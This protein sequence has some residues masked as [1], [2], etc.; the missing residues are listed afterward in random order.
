MAKGLI[1]EAREL[2][3]KKLMMVD[4]VQPVDSTQA[5]SQTD[6]Q[7]DS[8]ADSARVPP[9]NWDSMVDN[10]S[11]SQVGWSF[12]D[13]ERNKFAVDGQWWLYKRMFEEQRL[14]EQ[15]VDEGTGAAK[16]KKEAAEA[17]DR[18]IVRFQELILIIMY[19]WGGQ[20]PRTPE[21][22]GIRWKNT[23]QGGIRNI[24]I[25]DGLVAW[26]AAYHK[27]YRHSGNIKTIH[28]YLPREVGELLVYYLWLVVSFHDK[29]Q[30]QAIGQRCNSAFLWGNGEKKEHRQWTGP[31]RGRRR[32]K[33][34]KDKERDDE[35]RRNSEEVEDGEKG[36]EMAAEWTSE[37]MRKIMQK[38]SMRWMGVKIPIRGWREVSI[39][40]SR[41]F[42]RENA[43]RSGESGQDGDGWEDDV[44][45][46]P[47]DLQA[48]HGTHVA[49]MIYARELMEGRDAI[50]SRREKFRQVS[51]AWHRFLK[52]D[53]DSGIAGQKRKRSAVGDGI[54][55]AQQAR[56]KRLREV[57]IQQ[58]L[59]QMMGDKA[60]FRGL[61]EPAIKAIMKNESPILVVMS[62]GA[63][64]TL[65]FQLP[66]HS[67][68]SGTTV[69]IVPLKSLERDLHE[70]CQKAGISCI[71]W[72][73]R[74][75][76][77]MAQV[78]L[79]QP[80]SAVTMKFAQYLNRLQG[81]GRLDRV[82]FEECHTMMDSQP[83]FRP[84]MKKAGELM[85][86]RG[87]QLVYLTATLPPADE[88]EFF[89]IM[90]VQSEDV[91]I[92]RGCTS[93]PNIEYS[94]FE[95]DRDVEETEAVCQLVAEKL[96]Q[97]PAPAK[98]IVYGSSIDT[99]EELGR[100]LNCHKYYHDVGSRAQKD[101][102]QGRWESADGRVIV[103]SNAFGLGIDQPDVRVV[104]HVG[105]IH[106]LRDYVQES[107]RAGR[108]GKR[109]EAIIMR[110]EGLQEAM[111]QQQARARKAHEIP[112][113]LMTADDKKRIERGKVDKFISG[114]Q[115]RR[116]HLDQ[117][118][119]GRVDRVGCED[120]EEKCDVCQ[121][122]DNTMQEAEAL[123][124][125]YH[126]EQ[127][128]RV[129]YEQEWMLDS[130]IDIPS[131]SMM[132]KPVDVPSS[133][134]PESSIAP[135]LALSCPIAVDLMTVKFS[136]PKCQRQARQPVSPV[137]IRDLPRKSSPWPMNANSKPSKPEDNSSMHQF[138]PRIKKK[139][140]RCGNSSS[141]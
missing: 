104:I 132:A 60:E 69:V 116:I 113:V 62:T 71:R 15:F 56:W 107:G 38:S 63:G 137:P 124:Q 93:R 35:S 89:N 102:I 34:G 14:R 6:S 76:E 128:E 21:I 131:S 140:G 28:R 1:E 120:G 33:E 98:I 4:M 58:E 127:E 12:L 66:A 78:V 45:N 80:E 16:I 82:V 130:G 103:A 134:Q 9:I 84:K 126:A 77:R 32:D 53:S 112:R 55:E 59:K 48:G 73:A 8:Q 2:L 96:R 105:P 26:V 136:C 44:E 121:K 47:W 27:G 30:Y 129:R 100:G 22:L 67:Q 110:G 7:T 49:G 36:Q 64:K 42:C 125:A 106:R 88:S 86:E 114:S 141:N 85:M 52:G 11:E 117:E 122:D 37:R 70:R 18:D 139:D 43:F 74:E 41:R 68:K 19:I 101:E 50:V 97:Y 91:H 51:Q 24:F 119:D 57:N 108:D 54:Q 40:M 83:D 10:P 79:V 61:Q 99:I 115:C 109:S 92:F 133:S 23:E 90:K 111:Q 118:M 81:L 72:D 95:H 5:D 65:V 39:A 87:V 138:R 3:F 135:S 13:D 29:L 75:S 94:V 25:E 17:Y 31:K 20:V 123:R 46:D